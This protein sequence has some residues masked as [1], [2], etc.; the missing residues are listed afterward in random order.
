MNNTQKK[1]DL[2]NKIIGII[3]I[4]LGFVIFIIFTIWIVIAKVKKSDENLTSSQYNQEF[5]TILTN[6]MRMD[7]VYCLFLP[8]FFPILVL[9]F[10][11]RWTAF[12]YFLSCD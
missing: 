5:T 3:C 7:K 6:L 11:T 8:I 12:E 1:I 4:I 9:V 10:Y 2:W